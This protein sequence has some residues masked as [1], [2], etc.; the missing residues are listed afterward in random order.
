[1]FNCM[2]KDRSRQDL[3]MVVFH[4]RKF[5]AV[6]AGERVE[7]IYKGVILI[8]DWTEYIKL[9]LGNVGAGMPVAHPVAVSNSDKYWPG[10]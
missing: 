10:A 5:S 3:I 2:G 8:I 4:P 6:R 1:M 9:S 7:G